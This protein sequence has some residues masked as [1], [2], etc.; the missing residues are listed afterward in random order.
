MP[1]CESCPNIIHS[2]KLAEV[3]WD[4]RSPD[5]VNQ[6]IVCNTG[7]HRL[8][9]TGCF[10]LP[11]HPPLLSGPTPPQETLTESE[12]RRPGQVPGRELNSAIG[13]TMSSRWVRGVTSYPSIC[14]HFDRVN[15]QHE[16][17]AFEC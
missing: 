8:W 12:G 14:L 4:S 10:V 9:R 6:I 16:L 13:K 11:A 5:G 1:H 15:T 2:G 7:H 17:F 3:R